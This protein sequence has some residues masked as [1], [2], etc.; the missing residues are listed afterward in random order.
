MDT[1]TS[2]D[3]QVLRR[4]TPQTL[5]WAPSN[6]FEDDGVGLGME[7]PIPPRIAG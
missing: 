4:P 1:E 3:G 2:D 5:A 6:D 7:A